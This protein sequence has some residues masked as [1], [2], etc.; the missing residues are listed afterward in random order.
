[1]QL[2]ITDF[3]NN[4]EPSIDGM[5]PQSQFPF[6]LKI[7]PPPQSLLYLFQTYV[8]ETETVLHVCII[9]SLFLLH[10]HPPITSLSPSLGLLRPVNMSLRVK[11]GNMCPLTH[12]QTL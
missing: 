6:F 8:K 12:V 7:L 5:S 3:T 2:K 1:M 9:T 10:P 4:S 11:N